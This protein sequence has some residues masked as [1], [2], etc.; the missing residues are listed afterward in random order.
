MIADADGRYIESAVATFFT[1]TSQK[2]KEKTTWTER[3]PNDDAPS[4]LL[5]GKYEPEKV[6]PPLKRRKIAAFDL[7]GSPSPCQVSRANL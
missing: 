3:A 7:V 4:T 6:E 5:V 2:P 1:P